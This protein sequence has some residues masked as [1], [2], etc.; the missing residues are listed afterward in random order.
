M[1]KQNALISFE[2]KV[3][4]D[5]FAVCT[6]VSI[7]LHHVLLFIILQL[8][9]ITVAILPVLVLLPEIGIISKDSAEL[10]TFIIFIIIDLILLTILSIDGQKRFSKSM[11]LIEQI[12]TKPSRSVSKKLFYGKI[13]EARLEAAILFTALCSLIWCMLIGLESQSFKIII[14]VMEGFAFLFMLIFIIIRFLIT[15]EI[16]FRALLTLILTGLSLW[17][18]IDRYGI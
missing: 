10:A 11:E 2:T 9:I 13:T 7:S 15:R 14:M 8:L 18:I 4:F 12:A 3:Q 5:E 6:L 17:Q 1:M 16:R